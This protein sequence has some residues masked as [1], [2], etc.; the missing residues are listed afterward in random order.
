MSDLKSTQDELLFASTLHTSPKKTTAL[1]WTRLTSWLAT[2]L[3]SFGL[4]Y[5][6]HYPLAPR[7][8]V[9]ST[10]NTHK[11]DLEDLSRYPLPPN[12]NSSTCPQPQP[13]SATIHAELEKELFALYEENDFRLYVFEALGGALRVPCVPLSIMT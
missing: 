9:T 2:V 10:K 11:L 5:T 12:E 7:V 6:V 4:I 13:L 8:Q 3:F 1:T